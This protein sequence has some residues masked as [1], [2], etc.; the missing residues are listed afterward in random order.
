MDQIREPDERFSPDHRVGRKAGRK[1]G[2][3]SILIGVAACKSIDTGKA[4]KIA[5]LLGD[6]PLYKR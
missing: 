3:Y 5:D 2:A 1:D 4:V 6:A